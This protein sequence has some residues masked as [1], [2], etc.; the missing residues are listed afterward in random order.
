MLAAASSA[1]RFWLIKQALGALPADLQETNPDVVTTAVRKALRTRLPDTRAGLAET[2]GL[3]AVQARVVLSVLAGMSVAKAVDEVGAS[4]ELVVRSTGTR[5]MAIAATRIAAWIPDHDAEPPV[6][7]EY[8]LCHETRC[9][10]IDPRGVR[11]TEHSQDLVLPLTDVYISV[12]MGPE[13]AVEVAADLDFVTSDRLD[14]SLQDRLLDDLIAFEESVGEPSQHFARLV[15][16][17][18]WLVVLGDP[19]AGKTTLLNW[20]ALINARAIRDGRER[21]ILAGRHLG[22]DVDLAQKHDQQRTAGSCGQDTASALFGVEGLRVADAESEADGTVTVWVATDHPGAASC[23]DCR[24]RAGRVHEY[25]LT[26]PRD[27]RRGLDEVSVAWLQAAVE[28]RHAGVR[29]ARRSP[30]RLPADPAA[31]PADQP[32]AGSAGR[33][34]RRAGLHRGRGGPVA[35]RVLAGGPCR[36]RRARRPRC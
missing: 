12:Q 4:G 2:L 10:Y 25:V 1:R 18:R 3:T 29:R 23:P 21:V 32:A 14:G 16:D 17:R 19:G 13:N 7:A 5:W 35:A 34:G 30:S 9:G 36:V 20:L 6:R 26:R 15:Q 11:R 22:L 8:L 24:T 27:L 33:G 28:V 31:V